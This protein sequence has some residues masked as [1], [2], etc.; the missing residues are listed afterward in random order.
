MD[1][2]FFPPRETVRSPLRRR[3]ICLLC[4]RAPR[5]APE[6]HQTTA[7][8]DRKRGD[9]SARFVCNDLWHVFGQKEA[10]K[11]IGGESESSEWGLSTHLDSIL[12]TQPWD[13]LSCLEMSQGR[14]PLWA[15]STILCRT[16]SGRG[17]PL[18]NTPPSW[19]TPP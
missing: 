8:L 14:T 10:G 6:V 15:S 19:L 16:T 4:L 9:E 12:E 13:T 5:S 18:T 1:G 7:A 11:K 17:L 3:S 2:I